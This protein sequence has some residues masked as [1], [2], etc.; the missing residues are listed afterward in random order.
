MK[1]DFSTYED[2]L[3]KVSDILNEDRRSKDD[4]KKKKRRRK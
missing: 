1:F 2:F 3:N 4:K